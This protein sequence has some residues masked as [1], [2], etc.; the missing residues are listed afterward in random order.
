MAAATRSSLNGDFIRV[1]TMNDDFRTKSFAL[2]IWLAQRMVKKIK[3]LPS[4]RQVT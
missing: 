2:G 4:E 3:L 1:G